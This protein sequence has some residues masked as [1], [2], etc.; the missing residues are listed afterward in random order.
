MS[1]S[2]PLGWQV[3]L[4]CVLH[5]RFE[6]ARSHELRHQCNA[7]PAFGG[8]LPGI[9]EADDVGMLQALQHSSLFLEALPLRLG[10]L[11]ILQRTQRE[12]TVNTPLTYR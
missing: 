3:F 6:R 7:L 10:Q 4:V 8:P 12:H 2:G 9:I 1:F 11:A 5:S